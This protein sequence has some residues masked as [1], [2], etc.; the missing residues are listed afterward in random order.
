MAK[1]KDNKNTKLRAI[2]DDNPNFMT[3]TIS[4]VTRHK[5]SIGYILA[6]L[7]ICSALILLVRHNNQVKN[8]EASSLMQNAVTQYE[9]DLLTSSLSLTAKNEEGEVIEGPELKVQSK[10]AGLFQSVYDNYPNTESGKNAL[11]MAGVSHLNLGENEEALAA[12]NTFLEKFPDHI[13]VPSALLCKSTALFN[14]GST[15]E[16]L[17]LLTEIETRYPTFKLMDMLT[18]EQA[19]RYEALEQ[20]TLAKDAYQKVIDQHPD[21]TFKNLSETAL[22]KLKKQLAEEASD[23]G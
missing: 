6:G 7:V 23:I 9:K 18:Y 20:W 10:S 14:M 19:M 22:D 21:S 3:Q 8:N 1:Q 13:L 5:D 11:F 15:S 17:A 16:S 2:T 4:F 12:F